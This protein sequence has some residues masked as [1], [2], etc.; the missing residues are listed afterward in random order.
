MKPLLPINSVEQEA[1]IPAIVYVLLQFL[2]WYEI[3]LIF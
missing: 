2:D 3:F 1:M